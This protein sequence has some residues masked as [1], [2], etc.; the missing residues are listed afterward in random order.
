M[1][2]TEKENKDDDDEDEIIR[3][4]RL[5]PGAGT[6]HRHKHTYTHDKNLF[7]A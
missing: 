7:L 5:H 4:G 3:K 2:K 1:N 6:C